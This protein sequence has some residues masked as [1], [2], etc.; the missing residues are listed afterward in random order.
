MLNV[1]DM[2]QRTEL[3]DDVDIMIALF[4]SH[5]SKNFLWALNADFAMESVIIVVFATVEFAATQL[6]A[7][8]RSNPACTSEHHN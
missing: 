6:R 8:P 7:G 2:L 1:R 4:N 5:L 3:F